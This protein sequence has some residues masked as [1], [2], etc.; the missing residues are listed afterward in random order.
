MLGR[1]S[2]SAGRALSVSDRIVSQNML[3]W[4]AG[5]RSGSRHLR[6]V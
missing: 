5:S 6:H 1:P 3:S 4:C 2:E